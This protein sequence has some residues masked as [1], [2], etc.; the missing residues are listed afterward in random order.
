MCPVAQDSYVIAGSA[1]N[2]GTQP[3]IAVDGS[4]QSQGLVQ[5]DLSCLPAGTTG[6]NVAKA[7]MVL[8]VN[9]VQSAG[10]VMV[11]EADGAWTPATP[12]I[13]SGL[14]KPRALEEENDE[15]SDLLSFC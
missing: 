14:R 4:Q 10:S 9:T 15:H 2:Y 5:F 13:Q 3:T 11:E 1:A 7:T 6:S 12:F 8:Y